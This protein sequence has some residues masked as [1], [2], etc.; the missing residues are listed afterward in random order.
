[1]TAV[2]VDGQVVSFTV[3]FGGSNYTAAPTVELTGGNCSLQAE[4]QAT[5]DP[6]T[7]TVTSVS[8]V[9]A[10]LTP[11]G[12]RSGRQLAQ[13]TRRDQNLEGDGFNESRLTQLYDNN[14]RCGWRFKPPVPTG[15]K[16]RL[17][18]EHI[19]TEAGSDIIRLFD[20]AIDQWRGRADEFRYGTPQQ[21]RDAPLLLSA[22]GSHAA[23]TRIPSTDAALLIFTTDGS[24]QR[25][26]GF[27]LTWQ[28]Q[29]LQPPEQPA[30]P[31][32]DAESVTVSSG[33]VRWVAPS[34]ALPL[35]HWLLQRWPASAGVATPDPSL[36]LSTVLPASVLE[37]TLTGLEIGTSYMIRVQA[38]T[39]GVDSSSCLNGENFK[40][41]L[42]SSTLNLTTAIATVSWHISPSGSYLYA[43]GTEAA[44]YPMSIQS[45][46]EDPRVQNG[47]E[48]VLL[49]GTYGDQFMR[50]PGRSQDL[51][52][53]GKLLSIRSKNGAANTVIDCGGTSRFLTF[54][55]SEPANV[56]VRGVTLR[57]CG[58][59]A[60][61][62]GAI[63]FTNSSSPTIDSVV[64]V[65]NVAER[66]AA[67]VAD[68][69][70]APSFVNC[71]FV[72][73]TAAS[74]C[75]EICTLAMRSDANC[76]VQECGTRACGFDYKGQCCP[77][78]CQLMFA[79]GSCD[80]LCSSAAC[81]YDGGDC[82]TATV[83]AGTDGAVSC[84]ALR[85]DGTC[86]TE[87]N[88]AMCGFD[89]GDCDIDLSLAWGGFD[90][91]EH[92][93]FDGMSKGGA[94]AI[95]GGAVVTFDACRF[96]G[97]QAD[98]GGA[99]YV[100]GCDTD[101]SSDA[102][103]PEAVRAAGSTSSVLLRA[104]NAN[105]NRANVDGGMVS[106]LINDQYLQYFLA[107]STIPSIL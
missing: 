86:N 33:K 22:S 37:T 38:W 48:L 10:C 20:G 1:M 88:V 82:C 13:Y 80:A 51:N 32:V 63:F 2:V 65:D 16:L 25:P 99:L 45:L 4:A 89:G 47:H 59:P 19:D 49:D 68:G 43:S 73:N 70:A 83:S 14:M 9:P 57:N 41:S 53:Y 75:P 71:D 97:N 100:Q 36:I 24:V 91:A 8:I 29:P 44:P 54:N 93:G 104:T 60:D 50:G 102:P 7:G 66:G 5:I 105:N 90:R 11:G 94:G 61:G 107:S 103:C 87:C 96:D 64:F 27:Y 28:L 6:I 85:G 67:F 15:Y 77:S 62:R 3:D 30:T 56:V 35:V 95:V 92:V 18:F 69:G 23:E 74:G 81:G 76:D 101:R 79:D 72:N 106:C 12:S 46:I 78:A 34:S 39:E 21:V 58:S 42:H 31:I 40:C 17:S 55:H 52:L 84:T 98:L 26:G